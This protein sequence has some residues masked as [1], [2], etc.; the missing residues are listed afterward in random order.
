VPNVIDH[1]YCGGNEY[2][3]THVLPN[4]MDEEDAKLLEAMLCRHTD[5]SM[6]FMKG[7]ESLKKAAEEPLYDESKGCTKEFTTLHSTLKLL[8]LEARYGLFD[9]G[10]DAFLSIIADMLP[11]ENKVPANT[12][13]A[14]KLICPLAMDVEKIHACRNQCI[15]Y[16]GDDYKDLESCPKCNASRYKTNKDY[17]EEACV[18]SVSKGKKRKKA[19]KK[20]SKSTSKEKE[21]D[22]YA[23]K[24]IPAL[25]MWYLPVVDRF[26]C[27]FANREDAKLMSQHA[28]N[29]HK[30]NGKLRHPANGKQWHDF[31]DNHRDFVDE[32]RNV[33]F[34]V[35]E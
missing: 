10:F 34:R 11:K 28:S 30:N 2:D 25:V 29:E 27:L 22:Y 7:M 33:R 23:L 19:P 14:N 6:F 5:P 12:Y 9:A 18:A 15:L 13:Y 3:R 32:P 26:R 35:Y 24:K 20:T 4:V 31:N 21:V 1:G 17:L 8:M 16:R